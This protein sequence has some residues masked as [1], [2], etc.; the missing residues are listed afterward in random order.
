MG[1]SFVS[2][3]GVFMLVLFAVVGQGNMFRSGKFDKDGAR[4]LRVHTCFLSSIAA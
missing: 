2:K 3:C 1:N 4:G